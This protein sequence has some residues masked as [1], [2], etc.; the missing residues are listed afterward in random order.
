MNIV[1]IKHINIHYTPRYN[2]YF[3]GDV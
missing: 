2:K 3:I 1:N